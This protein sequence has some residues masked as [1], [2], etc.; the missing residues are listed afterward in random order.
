MLTGWQWIDP[1]VSL[2]ISVLIVFGT[3]G[4]LRDSV[5]LA[6]HAVPEGIDTDAVRSYLL[7]IAGVSEVHDLHI[8][9]M[10]TTETALTT[11]LVMPAGY[12]GDAF[13]KETSEELQ[14]RFEIG[15]CTVQIEVNDSPEPCRLAPAEVV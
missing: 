8:W 3:W 9:G 5:N 10:S 15:H 2:L 12:P 1:A 14:K 11:H 7:S 13:I 6:L 4:L